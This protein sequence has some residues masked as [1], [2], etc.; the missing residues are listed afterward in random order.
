[1]TNATAGAVIGNPLSN[2]TA[3]ANASQNNA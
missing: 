1:M 2:A 3:I